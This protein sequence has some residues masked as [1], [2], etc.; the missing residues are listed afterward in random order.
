MKNKIKRILERTGFLKPIYNFKEFLDFNE[1][2]S[3]LET[4]FCDIYAKIK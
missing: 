2:S 1:S 4:Q 3:F